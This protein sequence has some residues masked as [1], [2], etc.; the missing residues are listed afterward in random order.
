MKLLANNTN[1][2]YTEQW[3]QRPIHKHCDI[4]LHAVL[5]QV[6]IAKYIYKYNIFWDYKAYTSISCSPYFKQISCKI[7]GNKQQFAAYHC[8]Q[9]GDIQDDSSGVEVPTWWSPKLLGRPLCSS[10]FNG[11]SSTAA[12]CFVRLS[13][14]PKNSH[15][16]QSAGLCRVRTFD[17]EHTTCTFVI[18][19]HD[20]TNVSVQTED[21]AVP[22]V[23]VA[24]LSATLSSTAVAETVSV[25]PDLLPCVLLWSQVCLEYV[26]SHWQTTADI[27]HSCCGGKQR[28]NAVDCQVHDAHSSSHGQQT[29]QQS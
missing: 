23:T 9:K 13:D 16:S 7:T 28:C 1:L 2:T 4:V 26:L 10:W 8:L 12:L 17:V 18:D 29:N 20:I 27:T 19:G 21:V 25:V 15:F 5:I 6:L 11:R 22:P 3:L 14:G 24:L